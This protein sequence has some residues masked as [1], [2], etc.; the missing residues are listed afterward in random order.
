MTSSSWERVYLH[1][2]AAN[3]Q[4][5]KSDDDIIMNHVRDAMMVA[6]REWQLENKPSLDK[7]MFGLDEATIDL[8]CKRR[9]RGMI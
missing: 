5:H 8:I 7:A 1:L 6:F 2:A 9:G 4:R 3:A